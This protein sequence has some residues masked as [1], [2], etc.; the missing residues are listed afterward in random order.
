MKTRK[1]RTIEKKAREYSEKHDVSV[2]IADLALWK[3]ERNPK[4]TDKQAIEIAEGFWKGL[5]K[6]KVVT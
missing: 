1:R 2:R 4:L 6:K 5:K 3:K